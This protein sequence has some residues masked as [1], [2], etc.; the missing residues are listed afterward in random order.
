VVHSFIGRGGR[1][2]DHPWDVARC[3]DTKYLVLGTKQAAQ[4]RLGGGDLRDQGWWPVIC[5]QNA[6]AQSQSAFGFECNARAMKVDTVARAVRE[7]SG[8]LGKLIRNL[9]VGVAQTQTATPTTIG[10]P[11]VGVRFDQTFQVNTAAL[12]P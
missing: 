12:N 7:L 11:R 10:L 6:S 4:Q 1:V 5:H 2:P 8:K 9:F 3:A